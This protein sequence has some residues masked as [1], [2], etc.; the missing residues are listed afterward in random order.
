MF[1]FV[2]TAFIILT[3]IG[4]FFRGVGYG[5]N[6]SLECLIDEKAKYQKERS[7]N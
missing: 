2:T 7:Y 6:F 4:I 3:L 5:I 1:V